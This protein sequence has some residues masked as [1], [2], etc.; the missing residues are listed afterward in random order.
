LAIEVAR[1]NPGAQVI[2]LD[3]SSGMLDVGR[4]KTEKLGLTARIEYVQGDAQSLPFPDR[5]FDAISMA[6]GIRNVPDRPAAL[7]EMAR[8]ARPGAKIALLELTEPSGTG[9]S[10]VARLHVHWIVPAMG[11]IISGSR[12][13]AY[14]SRSIAAF[15]APDA[16][17]Q[18][19]KNSGLDL[20][21][22]V[23]FSFGACHLFVFTPRAEGSS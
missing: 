1:R 4:R 2:A 8:V 6:F 5:T 14:L 12:E 22:L 7:C 9:L 10:V 23:R 3:P 21:E 16:F 19:A 11:A 18:I 20:V 13:Y 17:V 15:P